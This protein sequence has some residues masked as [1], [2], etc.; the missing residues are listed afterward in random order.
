MSL[1]V[2]EPWIQDLHVHPGLPNKIQDRV[3]D[4]FSL[5]R[6]IGDPLSSHPALRH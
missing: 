4:L 6:P 3:S 2:R 1:D 5:A